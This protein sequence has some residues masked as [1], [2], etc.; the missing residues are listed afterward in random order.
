MSEKNAPVVI[1]RLLEK[2]PQTQTGKCSECGLVAIAKSGRG[3]MCGE[4]KKAVTAAWRARHPERARANRRQRS[5]HELFGRD[6]VKL[7][8]ECTQCGPV[9]MT[10]WGRGYACSVRAGQ[11]RQVQESKPI[12]ACRECWILDG[13][14]VY[15]VNGACPR[16]SDPRRNDVGSALRDAEYRA[17]DLDGL[18]PGF[19]VVDL[20]H[21]SAYDMPANESVVAGW[22]T[23]GSDRP[24]NEV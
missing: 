18:A 20:E 19:S 21:D 3:F 5:D 11:L 1:H 7:T 14:K 13:D 22:K 8:A 17:D 6:Y 10:P 15:P 4:K 2:D 23:V 16:C 12:E 9:G 24:W